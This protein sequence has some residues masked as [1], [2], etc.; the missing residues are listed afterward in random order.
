MTLIMDNVRFHHSHKVKD[1]ADQKGLRIVYTPPYSPD[2]NPIE[3]VFSY[4]KAIWRRLGPFSRDIKTILD[5]VPTKVFQK[6]VH[7]ARTF[8]RPV[9][10]ALP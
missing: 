2:F 8:W 9:E 6:C 10:L 5:D 1:L 3:N 4:V 7:R